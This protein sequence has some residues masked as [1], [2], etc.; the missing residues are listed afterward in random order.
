LTIKQSDNFTIMKRI[1]ILSITCLFAIH[2]FAQEELIRCGNPAYHEILEAAYPG[3]TENVNTRFEETATAVAQPGYKS[4]GVVYTIPVVVHIVYKNSTENISDAQIQSQLDVLNLD[5]R[6][7]NADVGQVPQLFAG[8]AADTEIE[9]CL[10]TVDPNGNSTTGITRTPTNVSSFSITQ[11]NI[12]QNGTG[13]KTAWDTGRYLNI[14]VGE[15]T[16][17][18]LGY[19]TPSSLQG[20]SGAW[21]DG[22]VI[23]FTYFGTMGTATF[24]YNRGRTGTHE[25][26]HYF[27][28]RHIW[29]DGNCS[30]DDGIADTPLQESQYGGCPTFGSPSTISCGSQD[31]F[32]NYMDYTDD[33]CMFMF[34]TGQA[35]AMRSVIQNHRAELLQN[36]SVACDPTGGAGC[37]DLEEGPITMGFEEGDDFGGWSILNENG[38]DKQWNIYEQNPDNTDYGPRSGSSCIV[39]TWSYTAA[40][41]DWFFTP[42]FEVKSARDYELRFW[43]GTGNDPGFSYPENMRV[44][45]STSPSASP[46]DI[47]GTADFEQIE[48]PYNSNMP[49]NNYQDVTIALPDYGDTEIYIGFQCYSDADQYA[50]LIDDVEVV[51][52]T[53]VSTENTITPEAFKTYPNPVSDELTL[54]F[55]FDETIENLQVNLVDLTGKMLY[56]TTIDNYTAGNFNI[57]VSDYPSGVYFLN[58]QADEQMTTQKVVVSK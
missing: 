16:G 18:I 6:K 35:N 13:G 1:L 8:L 30:V 17:G 32:M 20:T 53:T 9:F 38:D 27:D 37:R 22:V 58:V 2:T 44:V 36:A 39:Y 4:S 12:K 15:I 14:W 5:Y 31:M 47:L 3:F 45:T 25:V 57:N 42:C 29:G 48:Q 43:Y 11:E 28:L 26:G 46:D 34:T 24:P 21:R 52:V 19:A 41:D 54:D 10:A 49:N 55:N 23:G 50:M 56:T 40:A 33:R 51:D 7:M